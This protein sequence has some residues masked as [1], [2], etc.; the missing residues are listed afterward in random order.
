MRSRLRLWD[1]WVDAFDFNILAFV[2]VDIQ[3]SFAVDRALVG[4][5]GRVSLVMRAL[6]GDCGGHCRR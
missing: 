4:A 3:K 5:L 2:L 1:A 6:G